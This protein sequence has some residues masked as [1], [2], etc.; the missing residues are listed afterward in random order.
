MA[1]VRIP[2]E[3]GP[4]GPG[5]RLGRAPPAAAGLA[6]VVRRARNLPPKSLVRQSPGTPPPL[7]SGRRRFV[8]PQSFSGR[9]SPLRS[10]DTL[11]VSF[12]D[13]GRTPDERDVVE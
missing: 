13:V 2:M 8:R 11:R 4:P 12:H 5:P 10:R 6:N 9:S 7:F 3:A 1:A